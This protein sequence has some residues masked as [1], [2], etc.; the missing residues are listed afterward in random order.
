MTSDTPGPAGSPHTA[1][2][3]DA[4][5]PPDTAT[6]IAA[7]VQAGTIAPSDAVERS[8][9]RIEARDRDLGAF[10]RVRVAE[11]RAEARAL[12]GR[13]DLAEL[14]LAG[15][16]VA[17][18]DVM[19]VAGES[20]RLGSAA[21]SPAPAAHDDELVRRM[22]AAG[23]VIVGITAV[24]ELCIF[25]TTDSSFG[26]TRNPW[27]RTRTPGGSSGGSA[28]AVASGMVPVAH[29]TDGLGSI[30]IPAADCGLFGLKPGRD[31]LPS[32]EGAAS[33]FG[34]SESGPLATT[35][36]DAALLLSVLADRPA[37]ADP[38]PAEGLRIGVAAGTPSPLTPLDPALAAA[39]ERVGDAL[40]GAGHQVTR[41][42][43]P[44]PADPLGLLARWTRG[45]AVQARGLDRRQLAPRTRVHTAVG[46]AV[47]R[48]G[49]VRDGY[50][51]RI[52]RDVH[53]L[54]SSVD[55]VLTPTLL[56]T[57]PPA[58]RWSDRGWLPNVVSSVR[59]ASY[60]GLWNLVGLPAASVPAGIHP[61]DGMPIGVQMAGPPGSEATLLALA[62]QIERLLPWRR[63][64]P[65]YVPGAGA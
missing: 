50:V 30:R 24:P 12:A 46:R 25:P 22:R 54:F 41:A 10:R 39:L 55:V 62:A 35:V 61:G 1:E 42:V 7:A 32:G 15:V 53:E 58:R 28:A 38:A 3:P 18:K 48:L 56:Q 20:V 13:R 36:G 21:T 6:G 11:A 47:D 59:Y 34:M 2:P 5:E 26:I 4:A 29:G 57:A 65:A 51:R 31:L 45:P 37:L 23:A 60:P 19:A 33:W 9:A 44:Y 14:P 64:A 8:L 63:V 27:D 52:E 40:L 17:V 49:L 16:P 43:V